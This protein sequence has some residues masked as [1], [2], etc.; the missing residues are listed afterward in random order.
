[1]IQSANSI[2]NSKVLPVRLDLVLMVGLKLSVSVCKSATEHCSV[3][4]NSL[5]FFHTESSNAV[6]DTCEASDVNY[7][8]LYSDFIVGV[9]EWANEW[10]NGSVQ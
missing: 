6:M 8:H 7:N 3:A 1:M 9:S 10:M 5:G 4:Q 2:H